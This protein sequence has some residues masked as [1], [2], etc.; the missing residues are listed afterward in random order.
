VPARLKHLHDKA[1]LAAG[2]HEVSD[3]CSSISPAL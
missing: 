1:I 2:Y 3:L